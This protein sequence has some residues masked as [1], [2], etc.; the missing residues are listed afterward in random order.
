M[1]Q[2]VEPKES[3]STELV[4]VQTALTEFDKISA[5]LAELTTKYDKAV[6]P[7]ATA[8]GM[9]LAKQARQEIRSPRYAT[10]QA[11]KSA[12][13]PI[14]ALGKNIDERAAYITS[15]LTRL[16]EPIHAQITAEE[17]R[18]EDERAARAK[19]EQERLARIQA[20]IGEIK[21][22][23]TEAIGKPLAFL[24][25]QM[26]VVERIQITKDVFFEFVDIAEAAK[27]AAMNK[28]NEMCTEATARE[29]AAI[30]LRLEQEELARRQAEQLERERVEAARLAQEAAQRDAED[31]AR[32]GALA[33]EE[34][35]AKARIEAAERQAAAE[36]EAADRQAREER[37][38][39]EASARAAR[40]A[41]ESRIRAEA[42]RL[43]KERMAKEE[44]DRKAQ[45]EKDAKAKAKA[46]REEAAR[47]K[48]LQKEMQRSD[49]RQLL[50]TF[51]G[52][53]ADVSEFNE[54][55]VAIDVYFQAHPEK[56]A[57]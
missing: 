18:K 24:E 48:A 52:R 12:K 21:D 30:K 6:F 17:K 7:V 11:R 27:V 45:A 2:A 9:V 26:E 38:A 34:A 41:E 16:E 57:A 56:I 25:T 19:A 3:I 43:A 55:L 40:E 4:R 13:A 53:Y 31:R 28:L 42:D 32:R 10:E 14:I 1:D 8:A 54:I 20:A 29:E 35:A 23:V 44:R 15:E 5:G 22:Y 51:S 39:Q 36:R 46:D 47:Q 50:R 33:A 37:E 49:A